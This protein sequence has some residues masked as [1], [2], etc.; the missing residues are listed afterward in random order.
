MNILYIGPYRLANNAGLESVNLL[1]NLIELGHNV[2]ARPIFDG[3][4]LIKDKEI[5]T[6]LEYTEQNTYSQFDLLIQHLP[7]SRIV[8]TSK[9]NN[10]IYWPILD[11]TALSTIEKKKCRLID[12]D[13]TLLYSTKSDKTIL[14]DCDISNSIKFNYTINK[15]L[16]SKNFNVFNFGIYNRYKKYYT[17]MDETMQYA[18]Q[19]LIINFIRKFQN[20]DYCLV[21]F[22]P[23]ATQNLLDQYQKYIKNIYTIFDINYSINKILMVPIDY[24]IDSL[25]SA[26]KTGDIYISLKDNIQTVISSSL[27][28]HI[29]YYKSEPIISYESNNLKK[30]GTIEYKEKL[31]LDQS[32]IIDNTNNLKEIVERY[33]Q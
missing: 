29:I 13:G 23:N 16:L 22:L 15:K 28:K 25:V 19:N 9:I 32:N 1:Y 26:H 30:F 11:N 14:D 7:V 2:M 31:D 4:N 12:Q 21:I 24:N 10:N 20:N 18:I 17:I 3:T 8:K 6:I 5:T 27:G 33:A